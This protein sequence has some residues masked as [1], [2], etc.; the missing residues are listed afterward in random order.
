MDAVPGKGQMPL[1][2]L[3]LEGRQIIG[4][5]L[6]PLPLLH[7]QETIDDQAK[8]RLRVQGGK[9]VGDA[10]TGV[11]PVKCH[12]FQPQEDRQTGKCVREAVDINRTLRKRV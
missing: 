10:G 1:I 4:H 2:P 5:K 11:Q 8:Y 3:R 7:Q 12:L 9:T 6:G